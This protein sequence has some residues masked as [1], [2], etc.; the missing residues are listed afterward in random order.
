MI[1]DKQR[2][3]SIVPIR[4]GSMRGT[5]FLVGGGHLLTARHVV[6]EYYNGAKPVVAIF[7]G[8]DISFTPQ[9]VGNTREAIDVVVLTP[10]DPLFPLTPLAQEH[11]LKLMPIPYSQ[12]EGMKLSVIGYPS[13]LGGGSCQIETI[14]CPHTH[15]NIPTQKYDVVTVREGLFELKNYGGFSGSPVLTKAGYVVGVVSTETYG[16]LTYCSVERMA[17]KLK[18]LGVTDIETRWEV[19]EDSNLSLSQ[20]ETHIKKAIQKAAGRY[21]EELHTV[22]VQLEERIELF[23]DYGKKTRA[24]KILAEIVKKAEEAIADAINAG[25]AP[26]PLPVHIKGNYSDTGSERLPEFIEELRSVVR[27]KT[28]YSGT[29]RRLKSS[30]IQLNE[31]LDKM[32]KQLMC[33][34]GKA[35]MGKTHISCHIAKKLAGKKKNNVY[36]LFGSQ[37]ESTSDAWEK[38]ME[39]L[40]L[41]EEDV[42]R[43][44]ER[45]AQRN[46][47]AIFIIDALNEGAGDLYW[48]QQLNLLVSKIKEYPHLKLIFTIRDPFMEDITKDIDPKGI[49]TIELKGYTSYSAPK[50]IDKYFDKFEI[51]PK[52]KDQYKRQFKHPLFLIVFCNSY[53]L[54]TKEER[55]NLN[56][57]LLYKTYLTSRNAQVSRLAEE[58]EKRN[59]TLACMRQLAWLSVEQ[60]YSGLIP[61]EKARRIADK[62]CPMRT[63]RNNLLHALLYENLLME[64]LSDQVAGDLVMFEFENIAD[65]MKAESLLMSKLSEKQIIDLL[66]RTDDELTQKGMGKAKFNN[67]V[68]ALIAEWDRKTNVTAINEFTSGRFS[69]ELVRT[70]E[71]YQDERNYEEIRLWLK[72]N[73]EK[74]EPREMLHRLDD[75]KTTLFDTLH[76]YLRSLRMNERDEIWTIQANTFLE[77]AGAWSYLERLS[78]NEGTRS[79]FLL[80]TTWLLTTSN[81]DSRMFLTR[82]LYRRLLE[83][84]NDILGLMNEFER[85]NDHY[86][87]QGLYCAIY[88][89]SLRLKDGEILATIAERVYK[90]YYEHDDDVPVDIT[91]RQWTLKILE[92]AAY[93]EKPANYYYRIRL[94]FKSQDPKERMLKKDIDEN[95]FGEGKGAKLLYYSMSSGS[96]FHRY[97]IGSNSFAE[98]GEIFYEDED[99]EI[100]PISLFDI[101]KMM[102]PIIK[103]DYK[104][105]AELSRY[106][107]NRFSPER[108]HNKTERIGKKYQWLALDATYAKLTDN[109]L[110]KDFRSDNWGRNVRRKD[111]TNKAWPWM[112]RRYDR[113]DPTLPSNEEIDN[114]AAKIQL[115]PEKDDIKADNIEGVAEWLQS[116]S[117]HPQVR[118][119]WSDEKGQEWVRIYGF[120]SDEHQ[121]KKEE[122]HSMLYYNSSFVRKADSKSMEGWA[123]KQDFSGRWM[124][125]RSDCIDFLWNEMPWS[126]SYKRLNRDQWEEGDQWH[127]YPCKLLVAY[128]EQLQEEN[129]GFLHKEENYSYSASMPCGE[130]MREMKLYTAERG[131]VRRIE[132]D[133]I[134]AINLDIIKEKTGLVVRKDILC[135]YLRKKKYHLYVFILGNKEVRAGS[136]MVVDSKDLSGC[137]TMDEKGEWKEVQK[138]RIVEK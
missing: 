91:L 33:L 55:D 92:R 72:N 15:I 30:A 32:N 19:Y 27:P 110:V 84:P 74:Y 71:E 113:F 112:T 11:Y 7:E 51:D 108:H 12:S 134:A 130:M 132:D 109:Y 99:G 70:Q 121:Y 95:Y 48:K 137:M 67:M 122:R 9:K 1:S 97:T 107:G 129:Y 106:D 65:V 49:E 42:K 100:K 111:L 10:N 14:V 126:D 29:L 53:W 123:E 59:V 89:V 31:K 114:Y 34:H 86:L 68:R 125:E 79:R 104:Y 54:L 81:P 37:F 5:A 133:S 40:K 18:K 43:M 77:S 52:Y 63:W 3:M 47:Y 78:H 127:P 76:A 103:T 39:L 118:M 6:D 2:T 13:E 82:L 4:C 80:F 56:L 57:R 94:P 41:T 90:R 38:M 102:A 23:T 66:L 98:S 85:C 62:I 35:G 45:A 124:A 131:V 28:I 73:R 101:P 58:D 136:M 135:E 20:C 24:E 117:S 116:E 75:K 88:G 44:E 46:H 64:T 105:S 17:G 61:R 87:L 96:D 8:H 25:M 69:Y 93:M 21:H 120:E 22:N 50:A 128:D 16:K 26:T 83:K 36:L 138:L 119:Q 60:C 115:L